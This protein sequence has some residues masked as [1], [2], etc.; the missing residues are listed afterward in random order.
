MAIKIRSQSCPPNKRGHRQQGF[1]RT[2][3]N[4]PEDRLRE[5]RFGLSPI[6]PEL[7]AGGRDGVESTSVT[8]PE[9]VS[10]FVETED[11]L[12]RLAIACAYVLMSSAKPTFPQSRR[13]G[14][15]REV[16]V[17]PTTTSLLRPGDY[18]LFPVRV[19]WRRWRLGVVPVLESGEF[20]TSLPINSS[21]LTLGY[22]PQYVRGIEEALRR[23]Y[24]E[25]GFLPESLSS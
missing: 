4:A 24:T 5:Q 7:L 1:R 16:R 23:S 21:L 2:S 17:V 19:N 3:R 10:Q 13:G 11:G 18:G 15:S 6:G 12:N 22:F 9:D 20:D 8:Q 25:A 14:P